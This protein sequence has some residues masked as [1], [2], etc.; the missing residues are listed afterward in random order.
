MQSAGRFADLGKTSSL[1]HQT[2]WAWWVS[3]G[4]LM[5]WAREVGEEAPH[6]RL[7]GWSLAKTRRPGGCKFP[8]PELERFG[9]TRAVRTRGSPVRRHTFA[10][11]RGES[12]ARWSQVDWIVSEKKVGVSLVS[13]LARKIQI[14]ATIGS[15]CFLGSTR[16]TRIVRKETT[17]RTSNETGSPP[18]DGFAPLTPT[19]LRDEEFF[20]AKIRY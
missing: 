7:A 20:L 5:W 13:L 17:E 18:P 10:A 1:P 19:F 11:R 14:V 8:A 4:C 9:A 15:A 12:L 3:F 2:G 16:T 6:P